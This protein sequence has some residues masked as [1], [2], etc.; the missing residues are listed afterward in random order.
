MRIVNGNIVYENGTVNEVKGLEVE[1]DETKIKLE[2]ILKAIED[3]GYK[4][5]PQG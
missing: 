4:A 5:T 3:L 2:D 1:F